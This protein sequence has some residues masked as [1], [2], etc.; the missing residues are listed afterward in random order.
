MDATVSPLSL[1]PE[2]A[3]PRTIIFPFDKTHPEMARATCAWAMRQL[4]RDGDAVVFH[5]VISCTIPQLSP[6]FGS[7]GFDSDTFMI[8]ARDEKKL[9]AE[10]ASGAPPFSFSSS[11]SLR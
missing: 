4:L 10:S 8:E 3:S 6:G 1:P 11:L 2:M 9:A 5:T 7:A